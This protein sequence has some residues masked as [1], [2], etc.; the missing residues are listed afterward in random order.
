MSIDPFPLVVGFLCLVLLVANRAEKFPSM[1]RAVAFYLVVINVGIVGAFGIRPLILADQPGAPL[2][3]THNDALAAFGVSLVVAGIAT[4]L[5]FEPVR[6]RVARLFPPPPNGKFN[7]SSPA[8]A[9]ALI[10]CVYLIG[11]T[12]LEFVLAGGLG[13]LAQNFQAPTVLSQS[14]Q[15]AAFVLIAALGTGLFSR[16][17]LS[18]VITRLGLRLPTVPE[19]WL[20]AATA[21]ALI[22]L[23]FMVA[24]IWA[25][26]TTDQTFQQQTQL[27]QLIG[28]SVTTLT[29]AMFVAGTAAIGEELAFRGALQ[30]VFGLWPTAIIFALSHIQ[31][32]LTPA[33]LIIVGV[34]IGLGWLRRRYN[35][36]T[37][38]VAHF[39]YD[40]TLLA[41]PLYARLLEQA[42]FLGG[43]G[44]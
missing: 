39:M 44:K 31:Y 12:I 41:L 11:F 33:T 18:E 27:S 15:T 43:F 6:R 13:G 7:A 3:V 10:Y 20:G 5:M 25:S 29:F 1:G 40:F 28:Q 24:A 21:G 4:A 36:T 2:Q 8:Q 26:L 17:S 9:V 32:T 35:T 38:I 14:E 22:G 37:A 34:A 19:L 42:G 30:P 16:R 23:E